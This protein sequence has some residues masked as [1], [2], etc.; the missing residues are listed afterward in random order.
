MRY[1]L[2]WQPNFRQKSREV[3]ESSAFEESVT[4]DSFADGSEAKVGTLGDLVRW[5]S[6]PFLS[7]VGHILTISF[8]IQVVGIASVLLVTDSI[9][10]HPLFTSLL[11]IF[12]IYSSMRILVTLLRNWMV[13]QGNRMAVSMTTRLIHR[14]GF[15]IA[16]LAPNAVQEFSSGNLKT[17][18]ITD[19]QTVGELFHSAASRGVGYLIAPFLAPFLLYHL[20]GIPGLW[21]YVSMLL[22]IPFSVLTSRKMMRFFDEELSLEDDCTTITG[23]WLKN[24]KSARMMQ[25]SDYF[26]EKICHIKKQAFLRGR[27]GGYWAVFIFG[28]ATRWW[29]VPPVVIL[30][31]SQFYGYKLSPESLIGSLWYFSIL[32]GQFMGVPDLIIRGGKAIAAFRR[33]TRLLSQDRVHDSLVVGDELCWVGPY[34]YLK[35]QDVSLCINGTQ[36]LKDIN[37]TLDLHEKTALIGQLG[38]G[39]SSLL[40]LISGCQFPTAGEIHL[41]NGQAQHEI[42]HTE[43][44]TQWR[45]FQ[46]RVTQEPFIETTDVKNNVMLAWDESDKEPTDSSSKLLQSLYDA[47]M[48]EDLKQFSRGID[49][50]LGE[51]GINLSGG[52]KQRLNLARAH[53][54][55]SSFLILDDPLSAVDEAVADHI[56]HRLCARE[57]GFIIATHRMKYVLACDRVIVMD[58]GKIV[59]DGRPLELSKKADSHLYRMLQFAE[60]G[61]RH[62]ASNEN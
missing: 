49:E 40:S 5:M 46:V 13:L 25:A 52:Q 55:D 18:A 59:E 28:F 24:Q 31:T 43:G 3:I 17:M 58:Q 62:V 7:T 33:L 37:L 9:G 56:W 15:Q 6:R 11:A 21:A 1:R 44:Y 50:P 60:K 22:M 51:T 29:V 19:A 26:E 16:N 36:I 27:L 61:E 2:S 42:R 32:N 8:L 47:A 20:A 57:G 53:Y 4:E 10:K 35:M 39:K 38:A 41:E 45:E 23:E 12:L 30:F 34:H 54:G 14:L 48:E